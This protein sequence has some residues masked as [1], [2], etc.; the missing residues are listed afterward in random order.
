MPS[1]VA[2]CAA[3]K[4]D[5]PEYNNLV[6]SGRTAFWGGR[7]SEGFA[8]RLGL[9]AA[10]KATGFLTPAAVDY[11]DTL[12]NLDKLPKWFIRNGLDD[13]ERFVTSDS[14]ENWTVGSL[15]NFMEGGQGEQVDEDA[16]VI[17]SLAPPSTAISI[18][19]LHSVRDRMLALFK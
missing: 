8:I 11:A 19:N 15:L 16:P 14:F 3:A 6:N 17:A 9:F 4:M 10:L 12:A 5:R 13:E 2:L 7:D 1:I 18:I